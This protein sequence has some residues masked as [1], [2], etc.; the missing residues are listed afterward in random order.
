MLDASIHIELHSF[1]RSIHKVSDAT[2]LLFL[3]LRGWFSHLLRN[4][5]VL[6][7]ASSKQEPTALLN[8]DPIASRITEDGSVG[9]VALAAEFQ[10]SWRVILILKDL[11][12][13]IEDFGP[14]PM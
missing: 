12:R 11:F 1:L 14:P 7:P 6:L 9:E 10:R 4:R 8:V 5:L 2:R 13:Q 3:L